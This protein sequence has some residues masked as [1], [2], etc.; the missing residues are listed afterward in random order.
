MTELRY[1][2]LGESVYTGVLSN[3]LTVMV[4]PKP[5]FSRKLC[6][7]A[8]DFGSLH[9]H[10]TL[11]G[12]EY[13][14]PAGIAHYLEHKLFDMPDGRDVSA[15]FAALGASVNAFTSYDMTAYHFSC[16]ENFEKCLELLLSFVSTPYFTE[17]SVKK[18]QGIIGQEIAMNDDAPDTRV[19]ESLMAAMYD[20][21]PIRVPILGTKDTIA[22]ITPEVLADSHRAFYAPGNMV[23]CV[24]GDVD[25]ATVERVA[26]KVLGAQKRPVGEKC[27]LWQEEKTVCRADV[28]HKMEVAMPMFNLAFKCEPIGSGY[29]SFRREI[30]G[31]LASEALFGESSE[32]YLELYEEG[33]IDSSFGGGFESVDG[34]A[35]VLCSGDSDDPTAVRDA[36]L[37][38]AERIARSGIDETR[39]ERMKRSALGRRIRDLDSFS[40]TCFR[41]CAY[42]FAQTDYFRFPEVYSGITAQDVRDFIARVIQPERCSLSVIEPLHQEENQ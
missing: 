32:L 12:K 20:S 8:T 16:T 26:L 34:M 7:F 15:E 40:S 23:L 3:G 36:I 22:Q 33:L 31:D 13:A 29:D 28:C 18:E 19:F 10:F 1:P 27:R 25:A 4:V 35:M 21:H 24:V 37:N 41:L 5:G 38:Q 11:D 9:T 30:I 2:N 6:Y 42:H 14:A 17:E 39:L